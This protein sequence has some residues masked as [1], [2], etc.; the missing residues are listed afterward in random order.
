MPQSKES[1]QNKLLADRLA[2]LL[3]I[4][5]SRTG[6]WDP[7][8]RDGLY[9]GDVGDEIRE[10]PAYRTAKQIVAHMLRRQNDNATVAADRESLLHSGKGQKDTL[11]GGPELQEGLP[12]GD[13]DSARASAQ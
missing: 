10:W 12:A 1:S 11:R 3:V 2:I 4:C 13:D 9:D 7:W 6:D 8:F 5:Q